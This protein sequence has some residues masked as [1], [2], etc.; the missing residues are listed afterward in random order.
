[1]HRWRKFLF[2]LLFVVVLFHRRHILVGRS[3][4]RGCLLRQD[5]R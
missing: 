1:V 2:F 4:Q 5:L 3:L